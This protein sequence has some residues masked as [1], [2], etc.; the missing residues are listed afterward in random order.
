MIGVFD[1]GEGGENAVRHLK[2]LSPNSDILLYTDRKNLPYGKKSTTEL[3]E[4]T[5]HGIRRLLFEGADRV[6][7][8]CCTASSVH[9]ALCSELRA[10]SIPIIA[11]TA[12]RALGI[13]RSGRI[14]VIATEATVRHC[15]FSAALGESC[16]G[17]IP[18][19]ILVDAIEQGERDGRV[20]DKTADVLDLLAR[21]IAELDTDTLILG[22]THFERL[23]G[24]ISRR[25]EKIAK[26]KILTVN[27][28]REGAIELLKLF[29]DA[30]MGDGRLYR[31]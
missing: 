14:A 8:A 23:S 13:T 17:E 15:A 31:I 16:V 30:R 18:A 21:K 22:C 11:P 29:P 5:E 19:S 7:I 9:H 6:L 24:E 10:C 12:R 27:S 25:L 28:A 26:R 2:M 1:S 4:L 20:S 3:I